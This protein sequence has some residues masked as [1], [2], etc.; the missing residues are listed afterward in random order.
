MKNGGICNLTELGLEYRPD[1]C[2][3]SA[4][5][6][7]RRMVAGTKGLKEALEDVGWNGRT[8]TPRIRG[9]FYEFLGEP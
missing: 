2:K 4:R 5:R 3:D 8:I 1:I 6:M 7:M 9:I